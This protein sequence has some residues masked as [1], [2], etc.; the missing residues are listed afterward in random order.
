[1]CN[2]IFVFNDGNK[3][4]DMIWYDMI[5]YDMIWYDMIWYDMI[6]KHTAPLFLDEAAHSQTNSQYPKKHDWNHSGAD[7]WIEYFLHL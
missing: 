3:Y 7:E 6:W 5:W 4:G 1:M 2:C